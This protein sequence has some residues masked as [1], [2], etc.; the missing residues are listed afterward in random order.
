MRQSIA[1]GVVLSIKL[2]EVFFKPILYVLKGVKGE[3]PKIDKFSR[4]A[5][6]FVT[7]FLQKAERRE[8]ETSIIVTVPS[9]CTRMFDVSA[10][11]DRNSCTRY[12]VCS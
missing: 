4:R 8:R 3:V 5:V 12:K 9:K 1:A 7:Y 10:L 2:A 11:T 6:S